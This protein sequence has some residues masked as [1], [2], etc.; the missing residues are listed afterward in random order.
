MHNNN[1]NEGKV[2]PSRSV[3]VEIDKGGFLNLDRL[4]GEKGRLIN[5]NRDARFDDIHSAADDL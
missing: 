1:L 4:R 3:K 5:F 2:H